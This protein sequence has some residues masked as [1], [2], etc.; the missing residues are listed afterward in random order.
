[1]SQSLNDSCLFYFHH[2][3]KLQGLLLIHVDDYLSAGSA[4]F[5]KQIMEK[6]RQKYI[7]G[8]IS[9]KD[10]FFTGIHIKKD[11]HT[12]FFIDQERILEE[13]EIYDVSRETKTYI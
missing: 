13:I 2:N 7:F 5:E 4:L 6:L 10:F 8:K 12:N 1:M 3:N 9:D 11:K